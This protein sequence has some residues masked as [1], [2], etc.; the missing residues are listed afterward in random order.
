M[1]RKYGLKTLIFSSVFPLVLTGCF[2][3]EDIHSNSLEERS[4]NT[5][6]DSSKE[7]DYA[8]YFDSIEIGRA[9]V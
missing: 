5:E 1:T 9:H 7:F 3:N 2:S 8:S 4:I 6:D